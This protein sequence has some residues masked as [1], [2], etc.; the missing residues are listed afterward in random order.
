MLELVRLRQQQ[1]V[2]KP[3]RH[4]LV[5]FD[6]I[7]HTLHLPNCSCIGSYNAEPIL[8]YL[9]TLFVA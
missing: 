4:L 7:P 9:Q 3:G 6:V 8:L 1:Q 5:S 2:T